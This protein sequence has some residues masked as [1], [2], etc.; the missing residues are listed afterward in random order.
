VF[1]IFA[2][3][4][5]WFPLF[6]GLTLHS[7]WSKV[8]F[9]SIFIGVNATFFPQHFLGLRGI[10]RRYSDYPD[11]IIKWNI[12]SSIGSILSFL[13]LLLFIFI[14]WEAFIS[15]RNPICSGHQASFI[16]WQEL[17]PLDFHNLPE[18]S[19]ITSP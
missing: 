12:V 2:G 3:F 4:A 5:H 14:L 11:A 16:E 1:A 17:I 6:F 9:V 19:I 7:R 8:H 10:P 18:T 15:Q 13:A